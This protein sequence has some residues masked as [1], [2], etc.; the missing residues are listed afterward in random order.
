MCGGWQAEEAGL[1]LGS[2]Q[3]AKRTGGSLFTEQRWQ[4]DALM[5]QWSGDLKERA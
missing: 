2:V 3:E 5:G 4:R 1:G